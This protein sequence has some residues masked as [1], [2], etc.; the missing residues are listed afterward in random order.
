MK[1]SIGVPQPGRRQVRSV[2]GLFGIARP[3]PRKRPRLQVGQ[4]F[5]SGRTPRSQVG[6]TSGKRVTWA[7]E[8]R[9][10]PHQGQWLIDSEIGP[11]QAWQA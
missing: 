4:A 5:H 11:S 7:K 6:Q 8:L 9:V 3:L 2:C 10:V 1:R